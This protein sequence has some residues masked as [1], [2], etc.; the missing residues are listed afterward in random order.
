MVFES[1]TGWEWVLFGAIVLVFFT[2]SGVV[3]FIVMHKRRWPLRYED[4]TDVNGSGQPIR[5]RSGLCRLMGFG[6]NGE[7]ILYLAGSKKYRPSYGLK[8]AKNTYAYMIGRDG[9]PRNWV[10]SKMED[11]WKT[12][13]VKMTDA[14]VIMTRNAIAKSLDKEYNTQSWVDKYGTFIMSGI[15]LIM[16]I[17]MGVTVYVAMAKYQATA[18]VNA[19]IAKTNLEAMKYTTQIMKDLS[20]M[21]IKLNSG[22]VPVS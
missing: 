10:P 14:E 6:K 15:L 7:E 13:N 5:V 1:L 22:L 11:I 4:Y 9:I 20:T 17:V 19:E 18:G 12:N 8:I 3:G 16:I 2:V 21:G